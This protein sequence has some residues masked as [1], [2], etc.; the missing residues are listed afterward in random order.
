M[1]GVRENDLKEQM[2]PFQERMVAELE[3]LE[4]RIEKLQAFVQDGERT[5]NIDA[6]E[7]GLMFDQLRGMT[8]YRDFLGRRISKFNSLVV[9]TEYRQQV[10]REAI[11]AAEKDVMVKLEYSDVD[12]NGKDQHESGAKLDAGK[13]RLGLVLGDFSLALQQVGSVGTYGANKYTAHGWIDV[14]D[15]IERYLDALFR[16]LLAYTAG[17]EHDPESGI[18]HLSHAAWNILAVLEKE[19]EDNGMREKR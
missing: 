15:A 3:Q 9:P 14:P 12:P 16:H 8:T 1:P 19:I 2:E 6:G 5:R 11:E 4:E 10:E 17:E 18:P 13:N 7:I